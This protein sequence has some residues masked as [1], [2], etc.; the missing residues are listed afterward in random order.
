[1]RE[2]VKNNV[3]Y[4]ADQRSEAKKR[5]A[6]L[7]TIDLDGAAEGRGRMTVQGF[8]LTDAERQRIVAMMREL[9]SAKREA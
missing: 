8:I 7:F 5:K 1:M 9:T 3:K 4:D 6:S 2:N